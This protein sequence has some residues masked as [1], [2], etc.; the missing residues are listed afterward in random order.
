MDTKPTK[1]AA[2]VRAA[3]DADKPKK[4]RRERTVTPAALN[5]AES[6]DYLGMS[7][8]FFQGTERKKPGFPLPIDYSGNRTMLRWRRVD[9]DRWLE[10]V[11]TVTEAASEPSQ[12]AEGK[13]ARRANGDRDGVRKGGTAIPLSRKTRANPRK[14]IEEVSIEPVRSGAA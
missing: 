1:A 12:L 14:S 7:E 8:R 5:A 13:A 9:L 2:A 6:A 3:F 10:G 11:P 4:Q